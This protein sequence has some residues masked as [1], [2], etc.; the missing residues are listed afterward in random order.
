MARVRPP[1]TVGTVLVALALVAGAGDA[2]ARSLPGDAFLCRDARPPRSARGGVPVPTFHSRVGV[3]VVDRF[4]RP[5]PSERYTLDLE[6]A[7][8]YCAPVRIDGADLADP[9]SGLEAYEARRTRRK[10]APPPLATVTETIDT[11]FGAVTLRVG[12]IATLQVPTLA[13]GSVGG[14]GPERAHFACYDVRPE[15]GT[16]VRRGVLRVEVGTPDGRRVVELRKPTRLCVPASV[17]GDDP[18]APKQP[19]DLLCFDAR[20]ARLESTA[21]AANDLLATRNGFGNELLKIGNARLLCVPAARS[22]VVVPTA[23]PFPT[24]T[25]LPTETATPTPVPTPRVPALRI[26]PPT[27]TTLV[28]DRAC[29]AALLDLPD[30]SSVDVTATANWRIGDGTVAVPAG[31]DEGRK[32]FR[33]TTVGRT[34]LVARDASLGISSP[35]ARLEYEWPIYKLDVTPKRLGLRPGEAQ[36]VTVKATLTGDRVRNVTQYVEYV[37]GD[38]AVAHAPNAPGNRS[39]IEG[40]GE[41][42]AT[43]IVRDELSS[44][45]DSVVVSV[46]ALQAVQVEEVG[47]LF[48]GDQTHLQASGFFA[49]GFTSN[50]TQDVSYESSD[51]TIVA[52][53][54]DPADRNRVDALRPGVATITATDPATGIRSTCCGRVSVLGDVLDVVVQPG[55]AAYRKGIG[56][57]ALAFTALG[58]FTIPPVDRAYYPA[59]ERFLWSVTPPGVVDLGDIVAG[60]QTLTVLGAGRVDLVAI[61]PASGAHTAVP[62]TIYDH[63]DRLDVGTERAAPEVATEWTIVIGDSAS[64]FAHGWFDG[65]RWLR[66]DRARFQAEP[67]GVVQILGNIVRAIHPGTVTISAVDE[68]TGLTSTATGGRNVT[69]HVAGAV[70]RLVLS[71]A[72]ATMQIGDARTLTTVGQRVGGVPL[73][74]TQRVIYTSSD[75]AVVAAPN[76]S[77]NRS[78]IVAVGAGTATIS[79]FDPET[80]V[81]STAS[82]DD[83]LVT[84]TSDAVVRIALTPT[85]RRVAVGSAARFV[86]AGYYADGNA[87]NFTQRVEWRSSDPSVVVAPNLVGDRSRLE[88]VAP[89]TVTISAYD[90]ASGVASTDSGED[91]TLTVEALSGLSLTPADVVLHAGESTSLTT[92]GLVDGA[93]PI[94]VT[95]EAIYASSDPTVVTATN[96]SGNKSRIT[97]VAPGV[98]TIVA[99]RPSGWPQATESNAITVTVLPPP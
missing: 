39:R 42:F 86:A 36:S 64:Y 80:G 71:P 31:V 53:P 1:L 73:N 62:V 44:I 74:Y 18:A 58:L 97:A 54:N 89:G 59:T 24:L 65:G 6:K 20:M 76:D 32:C 92:V 93:D 34:D 82:G 51:P 78:R 96:A 61:D 19:L 84:V 83:T 88:A 77:G 41:G 72:A 79:A 29:V 98:A 94:N 49:G 95:Q 56:G 16:E 11:S 70:D 55:S 15:R 5:L 30:G 33:G 69:L 46:G 10:P 60:N 38:D 35:P 13:T 47:L 43:V 2:G 91:A 8:A 63:L 40:A 23:T 21:P 26:D 37:S 3:T 68:P 52:V 75:P 66:L 67:P 12:G 17:R 14:S 9:L 57:D 28:R 22:D 85:L 27:T 48:P 81:T 50:L 25:P 7:D 87:K 4:T 45:F 90:A 99:T